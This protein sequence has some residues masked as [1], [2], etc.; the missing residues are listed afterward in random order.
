MMTNMWITCN[1]TY[2]RC[3]EDPNIA[4]TCSGPSSCPQSSTVKANGGRG[5]FVS[6][7]ISLACSRSQV[8]E[9]GRVTLTR[10]PVKCMRGVLLRKRTEPTRK[11]HLE[12]KRYGTFGVLVLLKRGVYV[13]RWL[14]KSHVAEPISSIPCAIPIPAR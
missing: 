10:A 14:V 9:L 4:G 12:T 5:H 11:G 8:H 6:L 3:G 1:Q 13:R 2:G 7:L